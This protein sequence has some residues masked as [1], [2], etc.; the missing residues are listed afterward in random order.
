MSWTTDPGPALALNPGRHVG[1]QCLVIGLA[2]LLLFA[3]AATN[4]RRV[5]LHPMLRS[6][7]YLLGQQ[8][9]RL[10]LAMVGLAL[11]VFSAQVWLA[12]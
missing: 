11:A 12:N 6:I 1:L 2:G 4:Q 9:V 5:M 7:I 8:G 10:F 3:A